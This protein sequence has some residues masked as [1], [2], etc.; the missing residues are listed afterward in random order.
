M[1]VVELYYDG[2]SIPA[3]PPQIKLDEFENEMQIDVTG[4][5][6]EAE[7]E[8]HLINGILYT[9]EEIELDYSELSSIALHFD[10]VIDII[11]FLLEM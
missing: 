10:T 3:M 11:G 1:N 8:M 4:F 2:E 5:I 7:V 6:N 9:T